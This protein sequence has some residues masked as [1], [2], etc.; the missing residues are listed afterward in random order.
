MCVQLHYLAVS[1][2]SEIYNIQTD[3]KINKQ[4]QPHFHSVLMLTMEKATAI[5][6]M[7]VGSMFNEEH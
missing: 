2:I 3:K 7:Q 4:N 1:K 6:T 5:G